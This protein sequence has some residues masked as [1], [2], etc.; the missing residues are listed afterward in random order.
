[1]DIAKFKKKPLMG[2][3]RGVKLDV[4]EPLAEAV[5]AAGLETVEITM[6]TDNAPLLIR[7]LSKAA[8]GRL[9]VGAG[10]VLTIPELESAMDAGATFIVMPSVVREVTEHCAKNRIPV[11]PGALTPKEIYDAWRSGA[12]MVKVFPAKFFGPEY[13]REIKGPFNKIELLACAGVTP[14]NMKDYFACGASAVSFGASVFRKEWL[15]KGDFR[16]VADR[17][18]GYVRSLPDTDIQV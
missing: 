7:S 13:F 18:G 5:I 6:N 17:V 15:D 12:T 11:F 9:T 8:K 10:T 3:I 4:I 2:I 14:E 16:S 1:M